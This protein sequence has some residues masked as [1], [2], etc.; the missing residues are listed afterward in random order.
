[1]RAAR[2]VRWCSVTDEPFSATV[3]LQR[4]DG[5]DDRDTIKVDVSAVSIDELDEKVRAVRDRAEEWADDLRSIQPTRGRS[6]TD[7]QSTLAS[8]EGEA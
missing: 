3:K 8:E 7:D 2:A 6:L 5:T 4:G 1:M